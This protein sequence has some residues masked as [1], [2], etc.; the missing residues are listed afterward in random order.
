MPLFWLVWHNLLL[1]SYSPNQLV[2]ALIL[3]FCN[4][5]FESDGAGLMVEDGVPPPELCGDRLNPQSKEDV[6]PWHLGAQTF[7]S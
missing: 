6:R 5:D 4:L 7:V 2:R 1:N 3:I